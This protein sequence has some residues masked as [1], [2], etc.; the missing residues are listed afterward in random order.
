V[1]LVSGRAMQIIRQSVTYGHVAG[2]GLRTN[3]ADQ[4]SGSGLGELG[5]GLGGEAILESALAL[6]ELLVENN[7]GLLDALGL[8]QSLV[9]SGTKE[10]R[11]PE[12]LSDGGEGSVARLVVGGE[13]ADQNDLVGGLELL[14]RAAAL[15][16]RD[17]RE[18]LLGHV[19][20]N[21]SGLARALVG[22]DIVG[23]AEQLESRVSLHAVA[24]AQLLLLG[25]VNL[26]ERNLLVLE[27]S[28]GLLVLGGEGLAVAAPGREDYEEISM[29]VNDRDDVVATYTRQERGRSP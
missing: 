16:E 21:G 1:R 12:L 2:V 6:V 27:L 8:G 29:V 26:C 11:V 3:L 20:D 17:R 28:S 9:G 14:E 13:V 18:G 24:L 23:T 19:G 5:D 7:G 22:L 15:E 25:A 10:E 4:G